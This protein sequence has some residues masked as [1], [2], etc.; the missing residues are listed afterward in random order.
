MKF[1]NRQFMILHYLYE[2]ERGDVKELSKLLQ[3]TPQTIRTELINLQVA[4]DEEGIEVE[5]NHNS[6]I[7]VVGRENLS[8][9]MKKAKLHKEFCLDDQIVLLLVLSPGF[10]VLQDIAD[11]LFVSK[12][13]A[14][15]R[16]A[17]VL[18]SRPEEIGSI[19]HH[20][21]RYTGAQDKRRLAFVDMLLPYLNGVDYYEELSLFHQL[22]FPLLSYI[23]EEHI[24]KAADVI[25]R[26]TLDRGI[27]FNDTS[28]NE[29]FLTLL[30]ALWNGAAACGEGLP[31]NVIDHYQGVLAKNPLY[32]E[33]FQRINEELDLR[34]GAG[35]QMQIAG[36]MACLRKNK[37]ADKEEII[38][39]MEDF[40]LGIL[41][42][43]LRCYGIDLAAD[44]DLIEG[45]ALHF[46]TTITGDLGLEGQCDDYQAKLIKKQY[47]L[48]FDMAAIAAGHLG[49]IYQLTL[50]EHE[51]VYLTI[52]FQAA[53]ERQ[54]QGSRKISTILVCHYGKAAA[55]L[56]SS[57]LARK[58]PELDIHR[59]FSH[60]E[61]LASVPRADLIITTNNLPAGET[62]IIYVTPALQE[63]ELNTI[64]SFI[65]RRNVREM[66][67]M[68]IL[69]A[70]IVNLDAAHTAETAI[71]L[72]SGHLSEIGSV[73]DDFQQS[74]L[75]RER[76]SA[77]NLQYIAVPHGD[78][79]LVEETKLVIGRREHPLSWGDS[80][81]VSTVFMFACSRACG[82]EGMATI[83]AFYR[84]LAAPGLEVEIERC[85][86][87]DPRPYRQKLM[88][89]IKA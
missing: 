74:V 29:I 80:Q 83:S 82:G 26:L 47:P 84:Q 69:E 63:T 51:L 42:E 20:G 68:K 60:R 15:K 87:L 58:F 32:L 46:Y 22:H 17:L 4:L 18:K 7:A 19:R 52:H 5:I 65:E 3:V 43:I 24:E 56:I 79:H 61:Y 16:V 70:E 71:T 14:E 38:L 75:E 77:T 72:L 64:S 23:K 11:F 66:L 76:I 21:I 2:Y 36:L 86:H 37:V 49:D 25:D 73:K 62:P 40:I 89:L 59:H 88:R 28:L 31:E 55:T 30:F 6:Q 13:S 1:T 85:R 8:A 27:Q 35:D 48:G 33:K 81:E 10:V 50:N 12:S 34:L 67:L 39:E 78:P 54:K 9:F 44:R 53:L 41:A 45:L 57:K